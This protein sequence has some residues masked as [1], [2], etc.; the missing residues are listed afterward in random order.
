[1]EV[2]GNENAEVWGLESIAPPSRAFVPFEIID[3]TR[4]TTF[5]SQ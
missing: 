3:D 5:I 4:R 2:R 1:M